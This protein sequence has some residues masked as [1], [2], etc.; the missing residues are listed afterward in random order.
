MNIS[1][2]TKFEYNVIAVNAEKPFMKWKPF[3]DV[4]LK[5][6]MKIKPYEKCFDCEV[7][8]S[9]DDDVYF[10]TVSQKGNR[11]FCK[12]CAEKWDRELKQ[13]L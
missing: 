10:C 1:K 13:G 9:D 8:F 2:V 11:F 12:Q 3:K 6:G 7:C 5:S 4:R